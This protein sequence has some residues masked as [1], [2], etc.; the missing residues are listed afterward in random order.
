MGRQTQK[1][2]RHELVEVTIPKGSTLSRFVIPDLPNLRHTHLFGIEIYDDSVVAK[3]VQTGNKLLPLAAVCQNSFLT[4]VNYGG[5][6][7]LKQAP[8]TIFKTIYNQT[9]SPVGVPGITQLESNPKEFVGQKVNYPKSYIEF[10][11][12]PASVVEDLCYMFSVYYSLPIA[13]EQKESG[14]SFSKKG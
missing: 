9:F 7:F 14:F 13:E 12:P 3:G 5:K 2:I 6:E 4:L 10:T 8:S 11:T 1:I